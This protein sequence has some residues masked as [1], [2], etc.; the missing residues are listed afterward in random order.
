M[1]CRQYKILCLIS[2]DTVIELL[3]VYCATYMKHCECVRT[4]YTP[5]L[6]NELDLDTIALLC[7]CM[8]VA[9]NM[10]VF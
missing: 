1:L 6:G 9:T 8:Y 3:A 2:V 7:G 5:T 4:V 10:N